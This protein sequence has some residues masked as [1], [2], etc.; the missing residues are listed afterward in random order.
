MRQPFAQTL[1]LS[2]VEALLL[3]AREPVTVRRLQAVLDDL[4]TAAEIEGFLRRIQSRYEAERS[5]LRLR[6][7]GSGYVLT[8][9]PDC[10][11][12]I[13]RL[14]LTRPLLSQAAL[15]TVTIIAYLQPVTKAEI[16]AV[17]GVRVDRALETL[18]E[19]ELI[20]VVG[21]KQDQGRPYLYGTTDRFL[22]HFGLS[23]L[24]E[25]PPLPEPAEPQQS[26]SEEAASVSS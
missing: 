7:F 2:L 15:E 5:G 24:S 12:Y 17:R 6:R 14:G 26:D 22:Q 23:D 9:H 18:L 16:E 8:T 1:G 21:R 3:A 20:A 25:L 11:P 19:L 4:Y 10:A 13:E